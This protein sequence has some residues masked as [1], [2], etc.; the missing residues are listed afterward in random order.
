MSQP[1]EATRDAAD[2]TTLIVAARAGSREAFSALVDRYASAL[3]AFLRLRARCV[4]DAEELLQ[5][6]FLRAWQRLERYDPHWRFRTWLF[7]LGQNL[8]I[9]SYRR[10]T[11]LAQDGEDPP[12]VEASDDPLRSVCQ[13][14]VQTDL[15]SIAEDVLSPS[16]RQALWLRYV[17]DCTACEI[18]V[19][20]GKSDAA[21]RVM[22]FRARERLAPH[23]VAHAPLLEVRP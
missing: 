15:W 3:L 13:A 17:E 7:A 4:E 21:V 12:E 6:T 10:P 16:A 1:S 9:S 22:L 14:E 18:G 11:A 20:L 8:T 23:L 5:E 2:V 19:V